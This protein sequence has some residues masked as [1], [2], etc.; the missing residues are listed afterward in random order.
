VRAAALRA[1]VEPVELPFGG[2]FD[3]TTRPAL[4]RLVREWEP[5]IVLTWMNRATRAMPPG[6]FVHAARMG[7]YYDLKYYRHCH[8]LI[9]NTPDI[10]AHIVRQGWPAERSHY[11][12]NFVDDRPAAP[13]DRA[14]LDTAADA[15]VLL[16]AGRLHTNK[17][18]DVLLEPLPR[19]RHGAVA[20]GRGPE[21]DARPPARLRRIRVASSLARGMPA[22]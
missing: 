22:L 21:R 19:L 10:V 2:W 14:S 3:F 13:A 6:R 8:H 11:L 16:A 18:F 1:R 5:A 20:G 9:G 15:T 4:R 7:G 12:P 17:A